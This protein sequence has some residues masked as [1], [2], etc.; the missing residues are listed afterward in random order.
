MRE[1]S[2]E[3]VRG[4]AGESGSR[5]PSR[6]SARLGAFG[7]AGTRSS[8][9]STGALSWANLGKKT[10][11]SRRAFPWGSLLREAASSYR[12]SRILSRIAAGTFSYPW[13][14]IE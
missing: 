10:R 6:A 9:C 14:S 11:A 4:N 2:S 12:P 3:F 1:F 7:D 13:T 8:R 5:G